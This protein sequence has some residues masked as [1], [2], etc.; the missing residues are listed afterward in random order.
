MLLQDGSQMRYDRSLCD[1]DKQENLAGN[2]FLHTT[3]RYDLSPAASAGIQIS[4]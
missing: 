2:R 4:A 3:V 1:F